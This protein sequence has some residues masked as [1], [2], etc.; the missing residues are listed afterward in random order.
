MARVTASYKGIGQMMGLPGIK[1][2]LKAKA[3][4][5]EARA[6][7]TAPVD[8][9]DYKRSFGTTMGTTLIAGKKRPCSIVYNTSRHAL[10]VEYGG[11]R[12]VRHDTLRKAAH[13]GAI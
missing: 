13:A 9:G 4:E 2:V 3:K 11:N 5:I 10:W 8:T 12:P 7:A 1:A 6:I